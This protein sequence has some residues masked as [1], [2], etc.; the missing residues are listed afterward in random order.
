M[1]SIGNIPIFLSILKE[2]EP[3]R[4]RVIIFR[5]LFLALLIT[6]GFYYAGDPVLGFLRISP[7]A[8]LISGGIILF[9]IGIKLV[10]P[11][12]KNH[13]PTGSPNEK[14]PFLVPLAI[15]LVAGP[16][17]LAT[18]MLY[19]RQEVGDLLCLGAIFI[20][21]VATTLILLLAVPL[22]KL[23][24]TRGLAALERLTGLILMMIAVQM[25]LDGIGPILRY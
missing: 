1:D 24:G 23:L 21:W 13:E 8:V 9:L 17:V 18:V 14:E 5:E 20:A 11:Q 2:I 15:P 12:A 4:Q 6:I 3:K 7:G 25:F 10:F 22:K 19:S 16:A